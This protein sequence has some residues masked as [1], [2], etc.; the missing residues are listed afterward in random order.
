[1]SQSRQQREPALASRGRHSTD[2]Y[3]T[4]TGSGTA[5]R[6]TSF[7]TP[8]PTTPPTST[9]PSP[10]HS[11]RTKLDKS[12]SSIRR[13]RNTLARFSLGA[14]L[15]KD[16]PGQPKTSSTTIRHRRHNSTSYYFSNSSIMDSNNKN[17]NMSGRNKNK[18]KNKSAQTA[19]NGGGG[20]R[21]QNQDERKLK[22]MPLTRRN[23]ETFYSEQQSAEAQFPN[24]HSKELSVESWL[25]GL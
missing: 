9:L 16:E 15:E 4:R 17:K 21:N 13:L 5:A 24:R 25:K 22:V 8:S 14:W 6:T 20:S 2:K 10:H 12:L 7:N 18:N 3:D 11:A 23:I 19:G 1:M